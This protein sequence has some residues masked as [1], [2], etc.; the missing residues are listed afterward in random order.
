MPSTDRWSERVRLV[1]QWR[2]L[3]SKPCFHSSAPRPLRKWTS[4]F[5][6]SWVSVRGLSRYPQAHDAQ[7]PR[8]VRHR[9]I[10]WSRF[11]ASWRQILGRVTSGWT[12]SREPSDC[13]A[14]RS[15]ACLHRWAG[16]RRIFERGASPAPARNSRPP[17][18]KTAGSAPSPT[19]PVSTVSPLSTRLSYGRPSPSKS[20]GARWV[21]SRWLLEIS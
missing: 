15:T 14:P 11:A 2:R 4:R 16:L 8:Q 6:A 17:A 9:W 3:P 10:A 13:R 18:L 21:S 19:A 7:D 1:Q 5:Q 12:N 20:H